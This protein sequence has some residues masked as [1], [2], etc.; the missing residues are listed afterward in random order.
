[1][2]REEKRE[3]TTSEV[4][5]IIL[6]LS[7]PPSLFLIPN[8]FLKVDLALHKSDLVSVI[9]LFSFINIIK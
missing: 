2:R 5:D 4:N 1:M 8:F 7:K 6:Y 3:R 9:A